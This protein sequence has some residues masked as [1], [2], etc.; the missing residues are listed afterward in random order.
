MTIAAIIFAPFA[1]YTWPSEVPSNE[2]ILSTVGLGVICSGIA[3]RVFFLL[4]EEIGPA[5]ASLVVYPNTAVAVVLG[6]LILREEI[7][8]ALA[9]GLPLVLAGSYLA[10][11]KPTSQPIPV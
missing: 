11:K 6:V 1:I 7:T 8:L 3:F 5:R 9:I 10:S 4:L 2:A